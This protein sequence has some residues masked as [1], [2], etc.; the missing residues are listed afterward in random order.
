MAIRRQ[1]QLLVLREA[2]EAGPA[3]SLTLVL[4]GHRPARL[5][6][7]AVLGLGPVLFLRAGACRTPASRSLSRSSGRRPRSCRLRTS[8]SSEQASRLPP[9]SSPHL[10]HVTSTRPVIPLPSPSTRATSRARLGLTE[11][12][13]QL[14]HLCGLVHDIGKVGLPAGLL[15]KPGTLTLEE[16]RRM[17]EHSVIGERILAKVDDYAEIARI[18][19]HH[20]ERMDGNGYPDRL[21]GDA[22][23]ASFANHRGCRCLQRDDI[24]PPVPRRHAKSCRPVPACSGGGHPVR[25]DCCGCVRGDPCWRLRDLPVWCCVPTSRSRPSGSPPWCRRPSQA[26][27]RSRR[28][29]ALLAPAR[30]LE[31]GSERLVFPGCGGR[32][33]SLCLAQ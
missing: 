22:D 16:R 21:P 7:R 4:A 10:T 27:P 26:S 29:V 25:H 20:H 5:C 1:W 14:A 33:P 11:E 8:V 13:Q 19:R 30:P 12:E 32:E 18:V 15:E 23:P 28:P 9:R 2:A 6:L 24:R 31:V 3:R 17:E